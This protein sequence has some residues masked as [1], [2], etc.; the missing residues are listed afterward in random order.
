MYLSPQQLAAMLQQL[1]QQCCSSAAQQ[2]QSM[3]RNIVADGFGSISPHIPLQQTHVA[4]S[5]K[6]SNFSRNNRDSWLTAST[7][8]PQD[9]DERT[10]QACD[11]MS[12]PALQNCGMHALSEVHLRLIVMKKH[13]PAAIVKYMVQDLQLCAS[14]ALDVAAG[15]RMVKLLLSL[16]A[17][18]SRFTFFDRDYFQRIADD[19]QHA[20]TFR[21]SENLFPAMGLRVLAGATLPSQL[22]QW[23]DYN[24]RKWASKFIREHG[25]EHMGECYCTCK[26][27]FDAQV[28]VGS[29]CD[30][31][32][33]DDEFGFRCYWPTESYPLFAA[34]L[35][36]YMR[37]VKYLPIKLYVQS[38]RSSYAAVDKSVKMFLAAGASADE[39]DT[40]DT[41]ARVKKLRTGVRG[42]VRKDDLYALVQSLLDLH[43]DGV[44]DLVLSF[45]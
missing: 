7:N 4:H 42:K 34:F 25:S 16:G 28:V 23:F 37:Y 19:R 27:Q 35:E 24:A 29:S 26:R 11:A 38:V 21:R 9:Y 20:E 44:S 5:A 18:A 41:G 32:D 3:R 1:L 31:S 13:A 36:K 2:Q 45:F 6:M 17:D 15:P 22:C 8:E 14:E 43:E 40:F 12:L 30:G 39:V 33:S 10:L